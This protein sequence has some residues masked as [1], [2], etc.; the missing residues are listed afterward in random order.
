MTMNLF[1]RSALILVS[2]AFAST[3]NA[4]V[5]YTTT[6]V[7]GNTWEYN[8]TITNNTPVNPIGE[9]TVFYTLGQYSNLIVETSPGN[10][11]SIAAQPDPGLP[12]D[13][14]FDAL[15]LDSGLG[16]GKTVSGFSVEFNYL[17]KGT[18][19]SQLFN[20]VDPN[21]F[22]TLAVGQTTAASTRPPLGAPEIDPAS[23]ISGLILLLGGIAVMRGRKLKSSPN[24]I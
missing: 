20:I 4:Q 10:W 24:L 13:G 9:L 6:D 5:T 14:F 19:G 7:S 22:E 17:G 8:Y 15:A 16:A 18:P 12:A 3:T 23:S 21:T 2:I 11:S 1:L